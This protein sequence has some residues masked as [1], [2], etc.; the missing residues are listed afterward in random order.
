[1]RIVFADDYARER[2]QLRRIITND[3][4]FEVVG[5][6]KN[7]REAIELCRKHRPDVVIMDLSM[8]IFTGQEAVPI[9][10]REK[11]VKHIVVCSSQAQHAIL[12]Q[13]REFN[14]KFCL[15]PYDANNA[16][17]GGGQLHQLLRSLDV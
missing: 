17:A 3:L 1:M 8:P 2:M 12:N 13:I 14:P 10:A 16:E 4:G 7:G 5:E 11:L 9:I 15:K 6:A